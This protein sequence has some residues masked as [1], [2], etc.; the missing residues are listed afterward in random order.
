[1]TI[2]QTS[3]HFAELLLA[4]K[5]RARRDPLRARSGFSEDI[6]QLNAVLHN[7]K[8]KKLQKI[9]AYREWLRKNQPCI[10]GRAAATNK[11]VFICL[12]EEQQ[13]LLM[14]KGDEDLRETIVDHQ[15]V[16]KRRAVHGLSSSFVIVIA[17]PSIA[18]I[19]P[20]SELKEICRRLMEIYID[21]HVADDEIVPR[22]EYV[23][24]AREGEGGREYLRFATL[25]NIFCAQGDK[26]W[27]HDHRT[28]GAIM[29]TSNALGHFMHCQSP[30][31]P[32]DTKRALK[33]SIGTILNAHVE[34]RKKPGLPLTCPV[35][36]PAG[37]YSPLEGDPHY[38]QYSS[39][40]YKGY[41]HTDHLIP[42]GFFDGSKPK[43][44]FDDLDFSYIH[45]AAN[46]EHAE[47]VRGEPTD[48]YTVK[49]EI[50]MKAG[51]KQ[52][53]S[54]VFSDDERKL[55]F[56]WLEQRLWARCRS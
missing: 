37:E 3:P 52:E 40:V 12:L 48:W 9:A 41:F 44:V 42:S 23:Y 50:W 19:E 28:P 4:A 11:Q 29:I 5:L 8:V 17:S 39:R 15:K 25:P 18:H 43:K 46:S 51:A 22:H 33:Q 56:Q 14:R 31:N 49:N 36:R 32:Y 35:H 38:D 2:D 6:Q 10:F 24:L 34:A 16:W 20:G 27:W 47:L 21:A 54:L 7:P 13:I 45:D 1:M 53:P 30:K 26:R 55:S